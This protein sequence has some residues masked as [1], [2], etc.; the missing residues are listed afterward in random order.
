M[1]KKHKKLQ[2]ILKYQYIRYIVNDISNTAVED[3]MDSVLVVLFLFSS[4]DPKSKL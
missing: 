3:I 1:K 4:A 2:N